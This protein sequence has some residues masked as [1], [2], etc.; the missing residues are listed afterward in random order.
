MSWC[1]VLSLHVV[2]HLLC[3]FFTLV[4]V[5]LQSAVKHSFL[6][7]LNFANFL[8]R[9]ILAFEIGA[10][11]RRWYSMQIKLWLWTN[12]KNSLL[13]NFTIILKSHKFDACEIEVLQYCSRRVCMSVRHL[14]YIKHHIQISPSFC[15][16]TCYLPV[17]VAQSCY[18]GNTCYLPY[19]L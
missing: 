7:H 4:P 10:F 9:K 18:D 3:G 12:S 6:P 19:F 5:W 16:C 14:R 17:A 13:F 11:S 15:T 2:Y 8:R 1:C